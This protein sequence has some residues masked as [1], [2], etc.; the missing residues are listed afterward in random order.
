MILGE[1]ITSSEK[2]SDITGYDFSK[3]HNLGCK[4]TSSGILTFTSKLPKCCGLYAFAIQSPDGKFQFIYCG[5]SR[6][7]VGIRGRIRREF[8]TSQNEYMG[9]RSGPLSV[10]NALRKLGVP[11]N[12]YVCYAPMSPK[13]NIGYAEYCV[14]SNINFIGNSQHNGGMRLESLGH[15]VRY[16]PKKTVP[17]AYSIKSPSRIAH[18]LENSFRL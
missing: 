8:L 5:M 1:T 17:K 3:L 10:W 9:K 4:R 6:A 16:I 11:L 12:F 2:L 18:R 14:L 15:L 7:E 13:E